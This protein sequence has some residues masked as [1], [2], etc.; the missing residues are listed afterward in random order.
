MPDVT[1]K[2]PN[3]DDIFEKW[4]QQTNRKDKKKLEK[5][6]GVKGAVFSIDNISA[7]ETVK[8]TMKEAAIYYAV[9]K[10][11]A[12]TKEKEEEELID[13][14][15][16]R[17]QDFYE[18]KK[19]VVKDNWKGD[20]KV[21]IFSTLT[22]KPCQECKGKGFM[23]TECKNCKGTGKLEDKMKI[24]VGEEQ[25]KEK[26]VFK[27]DCAECYG[28]GKIR[29]R[30]KE[31]AGYKNMYAYKIKSVPFKRKETGIPMLHSSAQTKYEKE[32]KEDLHKLIDE[33]EGIKFPNFKE[34]DKKAEPSLGYFNKNI[35]KT[36]KEANKDYDKYEKDKDTQIVSG[37]YLFP[38]IQ[39]FCETK[40][41]GKS[42]EIYAL[43]S[44]K[45]FMIYSNF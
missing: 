5:E 17:K 8:D 28:T 7:G 42:F 11:I 12:P 36:I 29:E 37:L 19:D 6:F 18:F 38:M 41:R 22:P 13:A 33:V 4:K 30:C 21:P 39:V 40:N 35:K 10:I 3:V 43:G 2:S 24:Y 23:E 25:D 32:I 27:Y 31:C 44:D 20:D 15:K 34:L 1:I 16:V 14:E 9:K 45:K 26:K